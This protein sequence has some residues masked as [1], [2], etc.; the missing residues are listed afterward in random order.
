M[1]PATPTG[2]IQ[3]DGR[4]IALLLKAEEARRQLLDRPGDGE[5]GSASYSDKHL[6]RMARLAFLAPD[7]A[8]AILE[9]RQPKVL[10][11]RR[12]LRAAELPLAWSV[13]RRMFGFA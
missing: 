13:Q 12:L 10:T 5:A 8:A 6:A 9:G 2:P 3:R 1:V 4:L 11:A 7:I